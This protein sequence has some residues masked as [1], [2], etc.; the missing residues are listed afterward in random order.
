MV[1]PHTEGMWPPEHGGRWYPEQRGAMSTAFQQL[2][3][4]DCDG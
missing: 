3:K 2:L 4:S 1:M